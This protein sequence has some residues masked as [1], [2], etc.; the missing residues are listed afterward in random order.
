MAPWCAKGVTRAL[1]NNSAAAVHRQCCC[2]QKPVSL[3]STGSAAVLECSAPAFQRHA[4]L[5]RRWHHCLK[6]L[7]PHRQ[8][9]LSCKGSAATNCRQCCFIGKAVSLS[10]NSAAAVHRQCC[11]IQKAVSLQSMGSAAVLECSAAAFQKHAALQRRWH[12]CLKALLPHG[13][14]NAAVM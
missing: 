12:H 8:C 7:L 9:T 10:N 4:P 14:G 1:S 2:I 13:E 11:H 6:A 5:Q 3:Q